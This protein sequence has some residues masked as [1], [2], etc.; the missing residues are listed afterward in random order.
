MDRN[1]LK[2]NQ[3]FLTQRSQEYPNLIVAIPLDKLPVV[4]LM[5]KIIFWL[6]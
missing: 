3:N 5:S 6:F 1:R 4:K 2:K